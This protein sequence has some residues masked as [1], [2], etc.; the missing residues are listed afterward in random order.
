MDVIG[1]KGIAH[2]Q[3]NIAKWLQENPSA[4]T[5]PKELFR[6]YVDESVDAMD[7]MGEGLK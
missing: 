1:N 5:T 7:E 4:T 6:H 2:V 3:R